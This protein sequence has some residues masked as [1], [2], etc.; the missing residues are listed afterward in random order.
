M[1]WSGKN[2][3]S[4]VGFGPEMLRSSLAQCLHVEKMHHWIRRGN[5]QLRIIVHLPCKVT[6]GTL[7]WGVLS[8][9]LF[10]ETSANIQ[11]FWFALLV[12]HGC[13]FCN[14]LAHTWARTAAL[15]SH[16]SLFLSKHPSFYLN[17]KSDVFFLHVFHMVPYILGIAS[18]GR[19]CVSWR[20]E[21]LGGWLFCSCIPCYLYTD[22]WAAFEK[23][24]FSWAFQV[25]TALPES[26]KMQKS[27]LYLRSSWAV[28]EAKTGAQL[29]LTSLSDISVCTVFLFIIQSPRRKVKSQL[30]PW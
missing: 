10:P 19:S 11:L 14:Q 21:V 30:C 9:F 1:S 20:W 15:L 13:T 5:H 28:C 17:C 6:S 23:P 29:G 8:I 26:Y 16:P 3:F 7:F 12:D 2:V 4:G 22:H 25:T 18:T 27:W 24:C